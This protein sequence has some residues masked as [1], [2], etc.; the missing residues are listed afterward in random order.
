MNRKFYCCSVAEKVWIFRPACPE[1]LE[2]LSLLPLANCNEVTLQGVQWNLEYSPLL[3]SHP[4]AISNMV[5]QEK[6]IFT[7][8]QGTVG[9][10]LKYKFELGEGKFWKF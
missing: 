10:Y 1:N 2:A 5:E 8:N 3:L 7:C 6:V 9:F 4:Y